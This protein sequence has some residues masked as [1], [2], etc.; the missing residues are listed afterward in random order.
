MAKATNN[1]VI[2]QKEISCRMVL[3]RMR[4]SD[5]NCAQVI[6][7]PKTWWTLGSCAATSERFGRASNCSCC[8]ALAARRPCARAVSAS[9]D[10]G[11]STHS[12]ASEMKPIESHNSRLYRKTPAATCADHESDNM[13][14]SATVQ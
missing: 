8:F 13:F 11:N 10:I 6:A 1:P 9:T 12:A 5:Q 3:T 2:A 14:F 4:E 7:G